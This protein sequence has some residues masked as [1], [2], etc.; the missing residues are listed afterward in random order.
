MRVKKYKKNV[1][2]NTYNSASDLSSSFFSH[3]FSFLLFY[4][5]FCSSSFYFSLYVAWASRRGA[6]KSH[7][8]KGNRRL[9]C[10]AKDYNNLFLSTQSILLDVIVA[11]EASPDYGVW[12]LVIYLFIWDYG[13]NSFYILLTLSIFWKHFSWKYHFFCFAFNLSFLLVVCIWL[14]WI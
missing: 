2:K 10:Q 1:N 7:I 6:S 9:C 5:V 11:H 14:I 13:A 3:H 4:A 8:K 12:F